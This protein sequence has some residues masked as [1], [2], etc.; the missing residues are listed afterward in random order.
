[1]P[2]VDEALKELERALD[3]LKFV[4]ATITTFVGAHSVA[5]PAFAPFYEELNRRA[6][7]LYIHPSGNGIDSPFVIPYNLRWIIGAPMEGTVSI[8]H[9]IEA[10]IPQ[11][12]PKLKIVNSHLGG[13]IPMVFQRLDNISKWEHPLPELP[14]I[15]AK[16][17][18][19][20]SVGHGHPPALRAAVDSMGAERICLGTDFPYESGELFNHAIQYISESGLKPGDAEK[21]LD[22]NAAYVLGLA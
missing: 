10:G 22:R 7:V 16:R 21:I 17:M 11:K 14:T 13:M 19:Y 3:Q 5:D 4:G 15:T 12:Y 1:L 6:T 20:C 18:W 8:M 9:L 2:H